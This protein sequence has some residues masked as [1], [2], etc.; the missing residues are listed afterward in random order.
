[1][2]YSDNI[3]A[4]NEALNASLV[5]RPRSMFVLRPPRDEVIGLI[6]SDICLLA[7]V[8]IRFGRS[9]IALFFGYRTMSASIMG[10]LL[11]VVILGI[12]LLV[13]S[14]L[15][16]KNQAEVR[17]DIVTAKGR[18]YHATDIQEMRIVRNKSV[19]LINEDKPFLK[20]SKSDDG[21]DELICWARYYHIPI[22]KADKKR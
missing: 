20:L 18:E 12:V 6:V 21:C 4:A 22:T 13:I 9:I 3:S 2:S 10:L 15:F 17:G 11:F 8:F 1:M 7:F 14:P 19:N 5:E 16:F